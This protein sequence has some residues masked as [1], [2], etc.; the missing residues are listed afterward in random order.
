VVDRDNGLPMILSGQPGRVHRLF[1]SFSN[2][3]SSNAFV[4]L[5]IGNNFTD[6]VDGGSY[7]IPAKGWLQIFIPT[8][9]LADPGAGSFTFYSQTFDQHFPAPFAVSNPQSMVL[10]Q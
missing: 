2:L 6:L 7:V 8:S 3:P 4:S 10:V 9:V 1:A 5:D